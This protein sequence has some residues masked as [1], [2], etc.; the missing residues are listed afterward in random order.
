P[1]PDRNTGLNLASPSINQHAVYCGMTY[2]PADN[3]SVSVM[4][5]Q[6]FKNS[7][8]GPVLTPAGPVPGT[9]LRTTASGGEVTAR[10]S[11]FFW[12][13]RSPPGG[14][15]GPAQGGECG[16]PQGRGPPPSPPPPRP[17]MPVQ[18]ICSAGHRW[19]PAS[20]V[21]CLVCG[22]SDHPTGSRDSTVDAPR[23]GS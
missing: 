5:G 10:A 4:Y 13:A 11:F 16:P 21:A 19:E 7:I 18:L 20:R 2:R 8:T 1:I 17:A 6:G 9:V 3:W 22:E 12:G 14:G 15:G 23:A